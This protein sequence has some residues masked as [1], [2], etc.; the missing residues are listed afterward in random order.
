MTQIKIEYVPISELK[1]ASYNPRKHSKEAI[2]QIKKSIYEFSVVDPIIVNSAPNR[3]NII[4]GGH[5]RVKACKSL[6]HKTVPVVFLD[7]PSEEKE[8]TLN[9]RL[10][11]NL[12]EWD[13]E[14]L[15]DFDKGFLANVGFDNNDFEEIYG[16]ILDTED[17]E[18]PIEQELKKIK[19]PISEL[20]SLYRLGPHRLLCAD[21]TDIDAVKK[22][23]GDEKIDMVYC[24]PIFNINLSYKSGIGGTKNYGGS[25]KDKMSDEKYEAF[26][27]KTMENA[28]AVSK[29]DVHVFYYSDQK[30]IYLI[31][32]IYHN[33][34]IKFQRTCIWLKGVANPT[35]QIAFSKV[36][37]PCT[38][39]V[40]GKPYLSPQHKNFDEVL[41]KDTGTGHQLIE[42]FYDMF[43]IWAVKKLSGQNY[44]HPTQKPLTLHDKPIR[45]CT[46]P[47][48]N[49]LSLFGGSGGELIAAHQLKR[50][51]FMIEVDP[52]FVDL[53]IRHYEF[54]T[55][56]KARK[57]D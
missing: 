56:D 33:I 40:R 18:F 24:D 30:Y 42:S 32:K 49:I 37:E 20:G 29:K 14:L 16:D 38:Y 2:E 53:I 13:Y 28:M 51:C 7:I 39:G 31:Q 27:Q 50:R 46:R 6:G 3:R 43:D 47:G 45:R 48:D 55:G 5:M 44:T 10:N 26:L 25:S 35:P 9:L 8:R 21:A 4:I 41:N 12:G 17:K 54:Y 15:K 11:R 23:V 1:E 52:I 36:Y 19:E 34:G 57:I 22:L